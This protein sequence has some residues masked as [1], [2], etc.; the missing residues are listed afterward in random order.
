MRLYHLIST[1]HALSNIALK[2]MKIARLGELND[3][4]ELLSAS[5]GDKNLR[6][7][8]RSWKERMQE[9]IGLLCFSQ[10]WKNPV[11]WSHY[12]SKHRGICL[13]FDV[14]DELVNEVEYISERIPIELSADKPSAELDDK[15]V[16]RLLRTKF[17]HWRYESERR[18]FVKLDKNVREGGLYF[19]SFSKDLVLRE[20]VLGPMCELPIDRVRSLVECAYEGVAVIKARLAFKWF[21]VVADE[22]SVLDQ[23]ESNKRLQATRSKQRAPEA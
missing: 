4:F 5:M 14:K 23:E 11:L 13:G 12:A 3:P 15:F 10:A 19:S 8:L 21:S 7:A 18:L 2:R 9:D 22:R 6:R 20:V 1:E 16:N 17:D